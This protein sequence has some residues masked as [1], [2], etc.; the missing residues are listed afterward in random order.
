MGRSDGRHLSPWRTGVV[1]LALGAAGFTSLS[2]WRWFEDT[3]AASAGTEWFA[4]YADV[5]VTPRFD[6]EEPDSPAARHVLLSFVVA[7]PDDGCEPTWGAAYSLDAAAK[8]LDL[9]RRVARLRQN[10]GEPIVSFGGAINDE[11]ATT[12]TDPDDLLDSYRTVVERYDVRAIDLDIEGPALADVAAGERRARAIATLQ[13]ERAKNDS[14][15]R[16]WL[17]VPV[18]PAGLSVDGRQAV[19]TLLE[20]GVKLSGV[21]VMTMDYGESRAAGQSMADASISAL[22]A[23]H[24]QLGSVYA[25]TTGSIGPATLWK[26]MGATPMVGQNDVPGEVLTVD[27]AR[28]IN[29]FARSK[30]MGRMSMWSLNRDRTCGANYPDVTVVSTSCSGV[31]QGDA[32]FASVLGAGLTGNPVDSSVTPSVAQDTPAAPATDDPSTS[33]YAIWSADETYV[34]GARIVWHRN[35]YV[36]KW[37]TQGDVPDDPTVDVSGSPWQLV[38]PVLPGEKPVV[39]PKLDAGTYPEWDDDEIY[40]KGKRVLYDGVP[41]LAQWWTQGDNPTARAVASEPGPWRRLTSAEL[42][43]AA[44]EQ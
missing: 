34:Q 1:V 28:R 36:A 44:A 31:D 26:R 16:V 18:S 7:S 23:A 38:G 24:D 17:T 25:D 42:A 8:D 21:N 5:T 29:D 6:F 32:S 30:G 40:T 13:R 3:Q 9:D 41:Y 43:A 11:L 10:D 39:E 35:V 4:G 14:D 20:N 22:N 33:P 2:G 12:C 27:A 19:A 37:W 15:L